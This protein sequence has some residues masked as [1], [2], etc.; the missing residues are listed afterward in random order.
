[1]IILSLETSCDDTSFAIV[2]DGYEVL[3][4]TTTTQ[5]L[6]HQKYGGVVPE[7]AA[8]LHNEQWMYA[9]EHCLDT[10]SMTFEDIDCIAC[11]V[12]PGL[13]TSLL[14]GTT[15]AST[16]S[17]M[18]NKPLIPVHH[19][20]GHISSTIINRPEL[21]I[22]TANTYHICLTVSGGHTEIH[23]VND[24][25]RTTERLSKTLDDACGEAYDKV[26][27]MLGMPYPGGK[28]IEDMAVKG[29]KYAYN[30]PHMLLQKDS[31]DFSFSGLKAAIYR[32]THNK[33]L[34][35]SDKND[36][37]ASFQY[38]VE[39][40][41]SKKLT[42]VLERYN[43]ATSVHFVGGVSANKGIRYALETACNSYNIPFYTPSEFVYCTD[44]AAMIA[45][46]AY[47]TY[48]HKGTDAY[49]QAPLS[50]VPVWEIE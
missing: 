22:N 42:R 21:I 8:R 25:F 28:Y 17:I 36:I 5:A 10:A 29:N 6:A 23:K 34:I 41:F 1:M 37:A 19:I 9:L 13:Q 46:A 48:L 49:K 3:S 43:D 20:F 26:A 16:V 24:D 27:V 45:S 15:V 4:M 14:I 18:L 7:L 32:L 33:T 39:T 35:D 12:G 11:T 31:L 38:R 2:K 50:P 44:N 30:L 40:V 47:I